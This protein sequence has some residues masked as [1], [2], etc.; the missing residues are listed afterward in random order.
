MAKHGYGGK[1]LRIDLTEQ[2]ATI[3]CL[4]SEYYEMYL[5]GRGFNSRLLFD[6]AGPQT[7]PLSPEAPLIFA[8]GA[9]HGTPVPT[10]SRTTAT[11]KNVLS[12]GHGDS[13]GG[14]F[15]GSEIK[16][17]GYDVVII[18]GKAEKPVWLMINDEKVDFCDASDL[19]GK[20]TKETQEAIRKKLPSKKVQIACIGPAGENLVKYAVITDGVATFGRTGVGAVMGSKNLKALVVYGTGGITIHD[21]S[22]LLKAIK[23]YNNIVKQDPYLI[24]AVTFGS[25]RFMW[26]RVKYGVHGACNWR[27]GEFDWEGLSPEIFREK[28]AVKATSC[29][30]CPVRCRRDM[31]IREGEHKGEYTKV[32]WESIARSMTMGI[33]D[34]IDLIRVIGAFNEM[35]LDIESAGDTIAFAMECFEKGILTKED[36]DGLSP[37]FGD[38]ELIL[39]IIKMITYRQGIGNLLADGCYRAS[40]AIG[41]GSEKYAMHIKGVEVTAADPRGMPVRAV[42][43]ATSTRG[44]DHLRSNPYVEEMATPEEAELMFGSR[45]AAD[46]KGVAGKGRMLKWSEDLVTIGDLLGLCKWAFYR[47]ATMEYLCDKGLRLAAEFYSAVTGREMTGEELML[48]AERVYNIE[49]AFNVRTGFRKKD[50]TI[51]ERFFTEPIKGGPGDGNIVERNKFNTILEE[52]YEARGWDPSTGLQTR[53]KLEQLGLSEIK[54]VL[55]KDQREKNTIMLV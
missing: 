47:S 15:I 5:G 34:S 41:K 29:P 53:A 3:D 19:W 25:T 7:D 40:L 39:K 55:E 4:P 30:M 33:T 22:R 17:A 37:A 9:L 38:A 2:K 6:M 13:H 52:Y 23:E 42:S 14:G 35:G 27:L 8:P 49:K 24:P 11:I 32:E 10:A 43:Y 28:H 12:G 26:H 45:E 48:A 50:D 1:I 31:M 44:S 16:Y 18:T 54:N 36:F 46:L 21:P 51:P 20:K